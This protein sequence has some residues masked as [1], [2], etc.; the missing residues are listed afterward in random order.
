M[1]RLEDAGSIDILDNNNLF[2]RHQ[3]AS[4]KPVFPNVNKAGLNAQSIL[5][6]YLYSR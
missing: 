5:L 2:S 1:L 4:G 3:E 6:G